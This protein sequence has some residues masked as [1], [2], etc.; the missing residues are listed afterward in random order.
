[1][2]LAALHESTHVIV[3][4]I[5][6]LVTPWM[7]EG[8][9]EYFS[10]LDVVAQVERVTADEAALQLARTSLRSGYPRRL[11]DFLSLDPDE[12]RGA[13]QSVHYALAEGLLFFMMGNDERRRVLSALFGT[14]AAQYCRQLDTNALLDE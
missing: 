14:T 9:A 3:A 13:E 12:W 11:R 6:G 10:H 8:L 5:L 1:T 2:M 4:G 7:H